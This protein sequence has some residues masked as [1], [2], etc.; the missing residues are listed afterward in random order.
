MDAEPCST[1]NCNRHCGGGVDFAVRFEP[2]L[3][4]SQ[5]DLGDNQLNRTYAAAL[6]ELNL[7]NQFQNADYG[8]YIALLV[9]VGA[10]CGV[11]NCLRLWRRRKKDFERMQLHCASLDD[12]S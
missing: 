2:S 7:P 8:T 5:A 4:F 9:L 6:G 12:M 3:R 1:P 10:M 11:L